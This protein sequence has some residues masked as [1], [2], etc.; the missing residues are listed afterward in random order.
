MP[1]S[2]PRITAESTASSY[3][4]VLQPL[5]VGSITLPNRIVFPAIQANYANTDGTISDKLRQLYLA[6]AAGGC[7][8]VV[9]GTAVVSPES[10]AFDRVMRL[11]SE[12][13]VP[14]LR[15][16]FEEIEG[17]GSIPG[18]QLIHYGR[19]AL[20]SVTGHDL[21][22]PSAIPCP[23]MSRLDPSYRVVAMSRE[24]IARVRGDFVRAA[25]RAAEAGA[26]LV[27][28][29]AAHGYLLAEF[30]SPYSNHR[31]DAYGGNAENRLRLIS[32]IVAA[33]RDELGDGVAVSVRVSGHEH[34]AG[35][36][37]PDSLGPLVPA[38]EQAGIDLLDVSA[39]VYESMEY[40]VPPASLGTT[41]HV[42]IATALRAR[43]T[44]PVVAVGSVFSLDTA[45][46]IIS[47]Q[48]ADLVAMGRAQIADPAIVRKS[49]TN[50]HEDI[51]RCTRC[52][53]CTF[54]THG[55]PQMFCAVNPS[56][57]R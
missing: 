16:L 37:T 53:E 10:V 47:S 46:Q 20:R 38:L 12:R 21:L 48:Q 31:S 19:Q 55:D 23:V 39:G 8:L 17:L 11:D 5:R 56:L 24:Q 27:E 45:Q 30:L 33:V 34:V 51:A 14:P 18:V 9:T 1:S 26:R 4:Q 29:H 50:R 52:N 49:V 7:G 54:W 22:A 13:C 41:P 40:I 36:L 28:I 43:A 35:G 3:A 57:G 25:V 42:G 6:I 2:G 32:E 15:S 44:V